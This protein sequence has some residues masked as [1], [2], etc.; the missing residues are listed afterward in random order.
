MGEKGIHSLIRGIKI[1]KKTKNSKK[2]SNCARYIRRIAT[3]RYAKTINPL[4]AKKRR[5][6]SST[7]MRIERER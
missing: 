4:R 7:K 3:M 6:S 1:S 5:I 2:R